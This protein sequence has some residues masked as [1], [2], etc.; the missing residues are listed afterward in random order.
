MVSLFPLNLFSSI[1]IE[2]LDKESYL[3][4]YRPIKVMQFR[5]REVVEFVQP[6]PVSQK[7]H[8]FKV[9]L[10]HDLLKKI[11]CKGFRG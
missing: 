1:E 11:G 4:W 3:F 5:F 2:I 6:N 9:L 10:V 8:G 7:L